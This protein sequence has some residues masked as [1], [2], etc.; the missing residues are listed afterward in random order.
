LADLNQEK[1]G[2]ILKRPMTGVI[3]HARTGQADGA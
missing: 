2:H 3:R 1:A